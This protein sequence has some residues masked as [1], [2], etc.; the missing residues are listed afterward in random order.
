MA[1]VERMLIINCPD[2]LTQAISCSSIITEI[3]EISHQMVNVEISFGI[4]LLKHGDNIS[5]VIH[6]ADLNFLKTAMKH[7]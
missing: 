5:E 3:K 4:E 7:E 2:R 1:P 6:R